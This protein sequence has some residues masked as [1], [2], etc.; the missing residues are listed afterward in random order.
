[1]TRQAVP[2]GQR[3]TA[4]PDPAS[5]DP[6]PP[7]LT[8]PGSTPAGA[9]GWRELLDEQWSHHLAEYT[10]LSIEL[11]EADEPVV[12][13]PRHLAQPRPAGAAEPDDDL[14]DVAS[15]VASHRHVARLVSAERHALAEVE[16]A[17]ARLAAGEH[18]VCQQCGD[19]IAPQ[20]LEI[21]PQTRFCASCRRASSAA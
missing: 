2:S 12:G 21:L 9:D 14:A 7:G 18:G 8:S 10:R 13:R 15:R 4:L 11:H 6:A 5:P 1:M 20:R 16:A 3:G 17:L 19:T